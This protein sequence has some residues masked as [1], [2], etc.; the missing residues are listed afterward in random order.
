MGTS[1]AKALLVDEWENEVARNIM[2]LFRA[3][4]KGK[5]KL[6]RGGLRRGRGHA[7]DAAG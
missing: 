7:R 5:M 4:L 3:N 2:T 6:K 1:T